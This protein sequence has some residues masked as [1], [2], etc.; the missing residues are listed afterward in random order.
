MPDSTG[1]LS[2][3][4]KVVLA[5]EISAKIAGQLTCWVYHHND[6]EMHPLQRCPPNRGSTRPGHAAAWPGHEAPVNNLQYSVHGA[7]AC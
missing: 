5:G 3:Q 7:V 2:E 6:W 4:E 1:K